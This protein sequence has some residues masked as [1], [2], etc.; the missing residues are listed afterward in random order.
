MT[1]FP[2]LGRVPT[3]PNTSNI[4]CRSVSA[5]HHQVSVFHHFLGDCGDWQWKWDGR[6]PVV[7][8]LFWFLLKATGTHQRCPHTC[9]VQCQDGHCASSIKR[10]ISLLSQGSLCFSARV[11]RGKVVNC[12]CT[13]VLIQG[14]SISAP[15][16]GRKL[17]ARKIKPRPSAF[18]QLFCNKQPRSF[19]RGRFWA[20]CSVESQ[21]KMINR[22]YTINPTGFF[23]FSF[24]NFS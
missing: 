17:L 9:T 14:L 18:F 15:S 11:R 7:K 12:P 23:F 4:C 2:Y 16:I 22:I 10:Q 3:C 6:T 24:F 19:S 21:Q 1:S 5:V 8:F 13:H 20:T